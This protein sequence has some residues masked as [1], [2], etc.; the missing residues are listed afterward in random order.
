M[1]H[2]V[3]FIAL[4]SVVMLVPSVHAGS[5][6]WNELASCLPTDVQLAGFQQDSVNGENGDMSY[7]VVS[8]ISIP[9][10]GEDVGEFEEVEA[11]IDT[12]DSVN[13]SITDCISDPGYLTSAVSVSGLD[14][15]FS[16][17]G[18][19]GRKSIE[20]DEEGIYTCTYALSVGD[21]FLVEVT[22]YGEAE[23]FDSMDVLLAGVK[24]QQLEA[25]K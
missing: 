6:D 25:L 14:E 12:D 16:Y 11:S 20:Q 7:A 8:Y 19:S 21:R 22:G 3:A 9:G 17:N 13:V 10:E 24:W 1:K 18:Y 15:D 5:I 2:V 23:L 4:L